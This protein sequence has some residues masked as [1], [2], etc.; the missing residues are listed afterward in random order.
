MMAT[1]LSSLT[2]GAAVEP[3]ASCTPGWPTLCNCAGIEPITISG[4]RRMMIS[5]PASV[6]SNSPIVLPSSMLTRSSMRLIHE[7]I[8]CSPVFIELL[9]IALKNQTG[10]MPTK[11]HRIGHS[12][13]NRALARDI[14]YV[15]QITSGIRVV[16][17]NGRRNDACLNGHDGNHPFDRTSRPECVSGHRLGGANGQAVGVVAEK[18]LDGLC[19]RPVIEW[20]RGAMSIDIVHLVGTKISF[21]QSTTHGAYEAGAARRRFSDVVCIAG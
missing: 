19:F 11:A 15:I 8:F 12:D 14:G 2:A 9:F 21:F 1:L 6:N 13:V 16:Q 4:C 20:S 17:V 3:G 5:V 10:I 7:D 18:G